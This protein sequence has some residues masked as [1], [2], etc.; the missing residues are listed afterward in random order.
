[1]VLRAGRCPTCSAE[2][3]AGVDYSKSSLRLDPRHD[4]PLTY[5][6]N[7]RLLSQERLEHVGST[8]VSRLQWIYH[9]N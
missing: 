8:S 4:T 5:C 9:Q 2:S 1:M 7:T 6:H 3:S